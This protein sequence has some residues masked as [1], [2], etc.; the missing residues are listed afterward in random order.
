MTATWKE[1]TPEMI[2]WFRSHERLP[3]KMGGYIYLINRVGSDEYK[4]GMSVD[5]A[6]RL[7][8][9]QVS[10]GGELAITHFVATNWPDEL[11]ETMHSHFRSQRLRGEWFRLSENDVHCIRQM[12]DGHWGDCNLDLVMSHY[13]GVDKP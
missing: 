4:I 7:A 5:L 11:E 2:A 12:R 9:L 10:N 1:A 13:Y 6:R 3:W 8:E